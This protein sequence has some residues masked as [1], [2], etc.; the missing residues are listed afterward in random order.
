MMIVCMLSIKLIYD[1]MAELAFE[2]N[3]FSFS[4]KEKLL[5]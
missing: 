2:F 4:L 3:L 5:L 1:D